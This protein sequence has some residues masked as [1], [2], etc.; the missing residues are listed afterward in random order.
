MKSPEKTLLQ[1][2]KKSVS[3]LSKFVLESPVVSPTKSNFLAYK[4]ASYRKKKGLI[5]AIIIPPY[6]P[7][8][9]LIE[10]A[11][12]MHIGKKPSLSE[13]YQFNNN[14]IQDIIKEF[15]KLKKIETSKFDE[16]DEI[17]KEEIINFLARKDF[18][19]EKIN[20]GIVKEN[21]PNLRKMNDNIFKRVMRGIGKKK[22]IKFAR[23]NIERPLQNILLSL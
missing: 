11:V 6:V 21:F 14:R 7:A 10:S 19:K 2:N 22:Q 12:D 20:S 23:Y 5:R 9:K 13:K 16:Q 17:S 15:L 1:K 18:E 4:I 8:E 3:R